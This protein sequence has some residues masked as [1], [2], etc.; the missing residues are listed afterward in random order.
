MERRKFIRATGV[1]LTGAVAGCGAFPPGDDSDGNQATTERATSGP[2]EEDIANPETATDGSYSVSIE[3]MGEVTFDAVPETWVGNNGSWA[4]MALALG[5]EPPEAVWLPS[6]YHTN[7]YAD[8]PNV[9]V[10]GSNIDALYSDGVSKEQFYRFDG[11]VH[12][13]DP[14]FLQNRYSGWEDSD[15]DDVAAIA[16]FFGNSSFTHNYAWHEGYRYYTIEEAFA[17]LARV[18]H[19]AEY[20]N[21][22]ASVRN[23]FIANLSDVVPSDAADRPD[24]ANVWGG[25]QPES[26]YPYH[27]GQGTSYRQLR[28]LQV[29]DALAKAGVPDFYDTRGQIDYETLLDADPDVLLVR[30]H[31]SKSRAEFEDQVVSYMENDD[32]AS[33]LRAVQNGDVY[34]GGPLYQGPITNMVVAERQ[35]RQL[36]DTDAELFDR[37][38]VGEIVNGNL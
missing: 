26:F 2:I 33:T 29:G 1:A 23:E 37:Q 18:F 21:A 5:M 22:M 28:D 16:P 9:S 36:Y 25:D 11:D 27:I 13:I 32:T 14:N 4:D 35:A 8:I 6:R 20:Y 31:E 17:K 10:D 15:I 30:G 38:R 19:R 24:V 3:P 7:Y 12:I 34:R